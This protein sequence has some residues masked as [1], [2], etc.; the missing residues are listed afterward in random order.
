MTLDQKTIDRIARRVVDLLKKEE[1]PE[2]ITTKEAAHIMGVSPD[3]VR[4][5][6]S[7]FHHTRIGGK[8]GRIMFSRQD[9]EKYV[10]Q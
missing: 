2:M 1:K 6:K 8:N 4:R 10:L 9:V 7:Q 5:L 3:R